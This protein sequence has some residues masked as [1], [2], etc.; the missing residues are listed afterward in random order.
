[1]IFSRFYEQAMML[2]SQFGAHCVAVFLLCYDNGCNEA[3]DN[4]HSIEWDGSMR[5][6]PEL[7]NTKNQE[8]SRDILLEKI[9]IEI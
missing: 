9:E 1:M 2:K 7:I 5:S 6:R 3:D 4:R 8:R